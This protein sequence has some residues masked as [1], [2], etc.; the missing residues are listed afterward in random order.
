[1]P[2]TVLLGESPASRM[3]T[4]IAS[5]SAFWSAAMSVPVSKCRATAFH[6]EE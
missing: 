3:E 5:K 4:I 1:M 2:N 6:W